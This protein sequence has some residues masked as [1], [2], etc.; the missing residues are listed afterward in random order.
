MSTASRRSSISESLYFYEFIIWERPLTCDC[1]KFKPNFTTKYFPFRL[2]IAKCSECVC[3]IL[4][5]FI[6]FSAFPSSK[7]RIQSKPWRLTERHPVSFYR[8]RM[9]CW[10]F[11]NTYIFSTSVH[12]VSP[13]SPPD[14]GSTRT[15]R[16]ASQRKRCQL[17]QT[18]LLLTQLN[19]N[20]RTDGG[21]LR[22]QWELRC[23]TPV[24]NVCFN[25]FAVLHH[26]Q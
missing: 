23:Q 16:W 12:F 4:R 20:G 21:G 2:T 7:S 6:L 9:K 19:Y 3:V 17:K 8:S 11:S 24:T 25:M 13:F 26:S 1:S 15:K 10:A 18:R 5:Q 14:A 22:S